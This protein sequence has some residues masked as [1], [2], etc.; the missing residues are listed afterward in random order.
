MKHFPATHVFIDFDE[1]LFEHRAFQEYSSQVLSQAHDVNPSRYL[2]RFDEYHDLISPNHRMYRHE[3][4]LR[5]TTGLSWSVYSGEV[6]DRVRNDPNAHFCYDDAHRFVSDAQK[7]GA[8]VR[9]LTYGNEAYQRFKI[10]LCPVIGALPVH[11][12][13]EPKGDYLARHFSDAEIKGYLIDDKAPIPL[14][15]NWQHVWLNREGK[16]HPEENNHLEVTNLHFPSL[17]DTIAL[18]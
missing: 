8:V 2:E 15:D 1:T 10:G 14:P 7:S 5:D 6:T 12:V 18:A 11:V 17:A 13:C 9:L 16:T 3:D 4:H